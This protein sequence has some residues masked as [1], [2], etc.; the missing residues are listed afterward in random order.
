MHVKLAIFTVVAITV[1]GCASRSPP[2]PPM[3]AMEAPPPP[4]PAPVMAAP[5]DGMYRGPVMSTDDSRP[6]CRKMPATA[7]T[8]VRNNTFNLG[9]M[10]GRIG[11]DGAVT[12]AG[13]RGTTMTGMLA[14]GTLDVTTMSGSCGYHYTLARG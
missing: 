9:G 14:N 5:V 1:A 3:L 6:R 12:M 7:Q 4:P 13:R 2:P 8:R 11:P 10:R